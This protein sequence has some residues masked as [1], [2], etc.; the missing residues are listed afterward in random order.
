MRTPHDH[1]SDIAIIDG[2]SEGCAADR[3]AVPA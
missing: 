3:D 2:G 1:V